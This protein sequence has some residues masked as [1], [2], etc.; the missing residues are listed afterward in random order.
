[1]NVDPSGHTEKLKKVRKRGSKLR[2]VWALAWGSGR[3]H[4]PNRVASYGSSD[5]ICG[6]LG[7]TQ[8]H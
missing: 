1:M 3:V 5:Y 4:D 2:S 7:N 6:R 8:L